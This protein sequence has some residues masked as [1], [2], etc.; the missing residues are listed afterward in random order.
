MKVL[1]EKVGGIL[2][3]KVSIFVDNAYIPNAKRTTGKTKVC[4]S[5]VLYRLVANPIEEPIWR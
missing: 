1:P 3:I 4:G 5:K 2:A